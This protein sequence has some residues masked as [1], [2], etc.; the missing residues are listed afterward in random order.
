MLLTRLLSGQRESLVLHVHHHHPFYRQTTTVGGH[1]YEPTS[2]RPRFRISTPFASWLLTTSIMGRQLEGRCRPP[3]TTTRRVWGIVHCACGS[4]CN[5]RT[6]DG[7]D[8]APSINSSR[9][10]LPSLFR[11]ICRK[12]LSVRFSGVLSSSGIFITEPTIL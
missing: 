4:H 11:S 7:S 5:N 6:M 10:N 12:I 2:R 9:L 8:L 3:T 1:Y